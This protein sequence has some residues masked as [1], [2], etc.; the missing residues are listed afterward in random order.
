MNIGCPLKTRQEIVLQNNPTREAIIYFLKILLCENPGTI[1]GIKNSNNIILLIA[2]AP[3]KL[4]NNNVNITTT[5]N[6]I[7]PLPS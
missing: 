1:K 6:F 7:P 5:N 2:V 3:K 4:V